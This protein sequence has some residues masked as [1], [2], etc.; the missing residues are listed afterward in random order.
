[1]LNQEYQTNRPEFQTKLKFLQ[2]PCRISN[3]IKQLY[4]ILQETECNMEYSHIIHWNEMGDALVITDP[5][6]FTKFLPKHFKAK[7]LQSFIRQLNLYDFHKVKGYNNCIVFKHPFFNRDH[8][9]NLYLIKRKKVNT[10]NKD[11][12]SK[13]Q[14]K[15]TKSKRNKLNGYLIKNQ[16]IL[17]EK[18]HQ[19]RQLEQLMDK[20]GN[21]FRTI[22][23]GCDA[24]IR[25]MLVL[26]MTMIS[27][28]NSPLLDSI[29]N[30][31]SSFKPKNVQDIFQ[32]LDDVEG[33]VI[34]D[35]NLRQVLETLN[36]IL[37]EF[38][39]F[40]GNSSHINNE[41][42][43]CLNQDA[44]TKTIPD[45]HKTQNLASY[46][47]CLA[48]KISNSLI[49]VN[50]INSFDDRFENRNNSTSLLNSVSN[51]NTKNYN[52]CSIDIT[53]KEPVMDSSFDDFINAFVET[54]S[55]NSEA[56]ITNLPSYL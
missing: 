10:I 24:W 21:E 25:Q 37:N 15:F 31:L 11:F 8:P 2:E 27:T 55:A 53:A 1:M 52:A 4:Q 32:S 42:H 6:E 13:Y 45:Y 17:S 3:F 5:V 43:N 19:N 41:N 48:S 22:K 44:I 28:P 9:D 56:S 40:K 47:T 49:R 38:I 36:N 34:N 16:E 14:R 23:N 51:S 20:L 7:S 46:E 12:K 33:H 30:V 26:L 54:I 39:L 50:Q 29:Q 18:I 35:V